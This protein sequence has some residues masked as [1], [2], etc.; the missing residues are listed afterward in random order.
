MSATQ[1]T[2]H[3]RK[4]NIGPER[5]LA[6]DLIILFGLLVRAVGKAFGVSGEGSNLL[7]LVVIGSVARGVRRVFAAPGTQIRK[8]RSSPNARGQHDDRDRRVQGD[9]RQHRRTSE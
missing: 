1:S 4:Q 6:G 2:P 9:S 8:A 3:G 5:L 7:T